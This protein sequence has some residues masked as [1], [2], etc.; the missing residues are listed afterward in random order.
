MIS[1]VRTSASESFGAGPRWRMRRPLSRSSIR[2]KTATMKVLRSIRRPPLCVRCYWANT[3][4]KEVFSL[5]QLSKRNLHTGL[6]KRPIEAL[7]PR[8][9]TGLPLSQRTRMR[10][11]AHHTPLW[12]QVYHSNG[13]SLVLLRRCL[14][15]TNFLE[16]RKAEVQLRRIPWSGSSRRRGGLHSPPRWAKAAGEGRPLPGT[17][18]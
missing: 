15:I 12:G 8:L 11:Q 9:T 4:R 7:R 10:L 14:R 1:M 13:L 6:A 2:Q 3:E 16:L 17:L 5:A 18:S